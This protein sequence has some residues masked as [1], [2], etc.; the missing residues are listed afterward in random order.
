M[1]NDIAFV[2][3]SE[4]DKSAATHVST[5]NSPQSSPWETVIPVPKGIAEPKGIRHPKHQVPVSDDWPYYD[6]EG[7]L[8]GYNLRFDF[9]VEGQPQKDYRPYTYWHN[10]QTGECQWRFKGFSK[11]RPLYGLNWLTKHPQATVILCEG[12]KSA[13]A[14]YKA[15]LNVEYVALTSGG[16]SSADYADLTPLKDRSVILWP[17][18]DEAGMRYAKQLHKRLLDE[19]ITSDVRI[20]TPPADKPKKWD[21]AD[22]TVEGWTEAELRSLIGSAKTIE[23]PYRV[24]S[25]YKMDEEG[26]Y[27]CPQAEEDDEGKPVIWLSDKIEIC[28]HTRN[29]QGHD[30]GLLLRWRDGDQRIHEQAFS[31]RLFAASDG[32]A[33]IEHLLDCGLNISPSRRHRQYFL[34]YLQTVKPQRM[35]ISVSKLG[36]KDTHYMLHDRCI[37]P[38]NDIFLQNSAMLQGGPASQGSLQEW[39]EQIGRVIAGNS[40]LILFACSAFAAP[41]LHLAG[42]KEGGGFHLY[43]GTSVGKSTALEVA[44]SIWGNTD[45]IHQWRNTDNAF[46]AIALAHNDG[47]LCLDELHQVDPKVLDKTIYMIA[48]GKP[49]GRMRKDT[50]LR[51]GENWLILPLSVGEI[52]IEQRLAE[53]QIKAQGGMESRFATIP[54]DAGRGYGLYEHLHHF[55]KPEQLSDHLKQASKRHY[56]TAIRTF[57]ARLLAQPTRHTSAEIA[58]YRKIWVTC[59][60]P[61]ASHGGQIGRV[62]KR[63][64]LLSYAGKLANRFDILGCGQ[65]AIDEG[66]TLCFQAWLAER[67]TARR[68]QSESRH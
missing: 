56:G 13:R 16:E 44:A 65:D 40:R 62:A 38:S 68:C 27:F 5:V 24:S 45:F 57:L 58:E 26:V 61:E 8:L 14:L 19:A 50:T 51:Q 33:L 64:A 28:A 9:V 34:A 15:L 10:T 63:F 49:K 52:T 12:E 29:E 17:D 25:P 21:A 6:A 4:A 36:W 66:L 7:Q 67:G 42:E 53:G 11:P 43:G 60:T 3:L 1:E 20:I 48:N 30:W 37:P 47:L 22:A 55:D 41:L 2:S 23:I 31:K 39:Q 35:A 59:H 54:A 32:K 46:E 18:H